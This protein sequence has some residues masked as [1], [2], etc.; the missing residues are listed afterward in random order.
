MGQRH[1]R[2]VLALALT[3]SG[4]VAAAPISFNSALPVS[5]GEF[6]WR[7][8]VRWLHAD[9]DDPGGIRSVHARAAISVLGY[10]VHH[11]LALFAVLPYTDKSSTMTTPAGRIRR[12][13]SGVGRTEAHTPE[14]T[15][16]KRTSH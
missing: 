9:R 11:K 4:G 8:Q 1:R 7:Q 5:S 6:V 2:V 14:L 13:N 15:S 12:D 10:G 3:A 16:H